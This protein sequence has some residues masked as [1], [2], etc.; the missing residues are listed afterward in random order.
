MFAGMCAHDPSSS[1]SP[2]LWTHQH[3]EGI[4]V[5]IM[6]GEG[7]APASLPGLDLSAPPAP[8]DP[9]RLSPWFQRLTAVERARAARFRHEGNAWAFVV[10]RVLAREALADRL[11][12]DDG[13]GL[14]LTI[15]P[16]GKPYLD[17]EPRI[18]FNISHT[19]RRDAEGW[20]ALVAVA[21]GQPGGGAVGVDVERIARFEQAT[22]AARYFAAGEREAVREVPRPARSEALAALWTRKEAFLKATGEGIARGLDTFEV[23]ID[24]PARLLRIDGDDPRRWSM[25]DLEVPE[26]YRGALVVARV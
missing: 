2:K 14:P 18:P 20:S 10:G 8:F 3:I 23:T 4:D 9:Y 25:A 13:P 12:R 24:Q 26:G 17:I 11:G 15:G 22:L 6:S 1:R 16:R 21:V 19:V 7:A 5:L